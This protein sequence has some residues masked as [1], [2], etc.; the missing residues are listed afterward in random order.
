MNARWPIAATAVLVVLALTVRPAVGRAAGEAFDLPADEDAVVVRLS[1][2]SGPLSPEFF[3]GYEIAI[4]AGGEAT[5]TITPVGSSPDM[6]DPPLAEV[7][8]ET[9]LDEDDLEDLLEELDERGFF[10]L[11]EEAETDDDLPVGGSVSL[12]TVTLDDDEWQVYADGLSD[13][14][15]R[16]L[17][18]AHQAVVA[19][20]LVALGEA[21]ED[22]DDAF[23]LPDDDEFVIEAISDNGSV[24]PEFQTGYL[25]QIEASGQVE[26]EFT[27]EGASPDADDPTGKL[28]HWEYDLDEEGVQG[29]LVVV[30][31]LGFF[32]LPP[33]DEA[34]MPDG[35]HVDFLRVTLDDEAL[36]INAY[37]LSEEEMARFAAI[38]TAV[39]AAAGIDQFPIPLF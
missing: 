24:A 25:I 6:D 15:H 23:D 34:E 16:Q 5:Y 3:A 21:A 4:T 36:E 20:V 11:A 30:D 13:D 28:E 32:D 27:P 37:G 17:V 9:E 1:E 22:D 38:Q 35:G 29:L 10:E 31:A 14:Q 39:A 19:A 2:N 8:L 7:V 33:A 26:A 12:L 18:D